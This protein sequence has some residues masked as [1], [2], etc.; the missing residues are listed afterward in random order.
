M[1]DCEISF[2]WHHFSQKSVAKTPVASAPAQRAMSARSARPLNS[3]SSSN[4][5][6]R[7]SRPFATAFFVG[8]VVTGGNRESE[9]TRV[10]L[11]S[12][13]ARFLA[14]FV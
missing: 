1:I 6:R 2:I 14:F 8:E 12:T 7:T 13:S 3:E 5:D 9:R 11:G 4:F 10:R